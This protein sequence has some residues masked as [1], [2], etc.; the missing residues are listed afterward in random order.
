MEDFG[1]MQKKLEELG[2]EAESAGLQRIPNTTV[3]L[4][5]DAARKVMKLIEVF[6]D[7]DDVSEVFHN[8]EMTDELAAALDE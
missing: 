7:D 4:D 6:E 8:L 5:V 3:K 2:I 1:S